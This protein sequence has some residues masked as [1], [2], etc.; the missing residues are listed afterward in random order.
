[1]IGGC[2]ILFCFITFSNYAYREIF[3]LLLIPF[4]LNSKDKNKFINMIIFIL[5]FRFLFL[6][7]YAYINIYDGISYSEGERIFSNIFIFFITIKGILDFLLMSNILAIVFGGI[8]K[9]VIF[10]KNS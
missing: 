2:V 5:T 1:M 6:F 4:L 10:K 7:P 9:F 3:V 8:K